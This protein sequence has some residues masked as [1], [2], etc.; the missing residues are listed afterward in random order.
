MKVSQIFC[1]LQIG[2]PGQV[3]SSI[4]SEFKLIGIQFITQEK[5][6]K[7]LGLSVWRTDQGKENKD[8]VEF[9]FFHGKKSLI[10]LFDG[11]V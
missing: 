5:G 4:E 3:G 7:Y 11:W 9:K 1:V 10:G 2:D 8:Q 6:N